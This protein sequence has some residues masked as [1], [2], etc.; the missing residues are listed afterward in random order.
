[1][2]DPEALDL[3]E[4]GKIGR[5]IQQYELTGV[6]AEL[7]TRWSGDAGERW[8][9]RSLADYFNQRVFA[10]ALSDAGVDTVAMDV[11]AQYRVLTGEE[12]SAGDR[13]ALRRRLEREGVDVEATVGDFVSHQTVHTF[14]TDH[15]EER[16]EVDEAAQLQKDA[17]RVSRLESRLSAV[18]SD[19]VERSARVG[20]IDVGD[21][22]VFVETRVLCTA[23]GETTTVQDLFDLGGCGCS[24]EN[25]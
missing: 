14:L 1:M 22:E 11:G 20:R 21:P 3:H 19:A 10:A 12:G 13:T 4:A 18:A 25:D 23:C 8:S 24:A 16:Y 9:L 6:P 17:D 5:V 15:L 7:A 2:A